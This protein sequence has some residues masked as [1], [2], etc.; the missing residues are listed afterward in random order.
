MAAVDYPVMA[1][2][3]QQQPCQRFLVAMVLV[4]LSMASF[5][6]ANCCVHEIKV[7]S[8][9]VGPSVAVE[10]KVSNRARLEVLALEVLSLA[11][12]II[13]GNDLITGKAYPTTKEIPG[14]TVRLRNRAHSIPILLV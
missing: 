2:C 6:R 1:C 4:C 10:P 14:V 5:P 7:R 13:P 12:Q 11:V 8:V 9:L 3:H